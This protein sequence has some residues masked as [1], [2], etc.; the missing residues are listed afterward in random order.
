MQRPKRD[1]C[2]RRSDMR[3]ATRRTPT[4]RARV[5]FVEGGSGRRRVESRE[6]NIH[7]VENESVELL[8]HA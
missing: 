4:L 2:S 5:S 3:A 6:H 1:G 7:E 8:E